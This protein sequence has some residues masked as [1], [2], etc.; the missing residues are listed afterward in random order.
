MKPLLKAIYDKFT[1]A[2]LIASITGGIHVGKAPTGYAKPYLIVSPLPSPVI[3]AYGN[4]TSYDASIQFGVFAGGSGAATTVQ[5]LMAAV[6][7]AYD[8][9][10][11]SLSSGTNIG[12]W[13]EDQPYPELVPEDSPMKDENAGDVWA[14]FC[15]YR[16]Q[17]Q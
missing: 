16:Y 14:C 8:N 5:D 3:D 13:R 7:A 15:T 9:A 10:V 6:N 11:L 4:V 12:M 17:V 1:S 2:G